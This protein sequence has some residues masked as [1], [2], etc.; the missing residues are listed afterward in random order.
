M[1]SPLDGGVALH[2]PIILDLGVTSHVG[3][4]HPSV[5]DLP[6]APRGRHGVRPAPPLWAAAVVMPLQ[7]GCQGYRHRSCHDGV[8]AEQ[9][10]RSSESLYL[11]CLILVG[12][13]RPPF[14][15]SAGEPEPVGAAG[16]CVLLLQCYVVMGAGW[17]SLDPM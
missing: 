5:N 4:D 14:G 1:G 13:G 7:V 11:V 2:G 16:I 6:C 15:P 17:G 12:P 9:C 3:P 8:R 10:Q